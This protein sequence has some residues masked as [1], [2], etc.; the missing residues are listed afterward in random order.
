[1]ADIQEMLC[2]SLG[3]GDFH[4]RDAQRLHQRRRIVVC[5]ISSTE[6]WHRDAHNTLAIVSE[7]VKSAYAHQQ[8]QRRVQTT[9]DAYHHML[10]IGMYQPLGEPCRLDV[11]NL[12]A[13][14]CH[15]VIVG[16]ERMRIDRTRQLEGMLVAHGLAS[17]HL[18][19]SATLGVDE[20]GIGL[21]L[22]MQS[23]D[24]YLGSV[25]N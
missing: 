16:D 13:G 4:L 1:M 24:V 19:V 8:R 14:F 21:P 12:L 15:I 9:T 20:G 5:T 6:S 7:F 2:H 11:E 23:L 17:Y 18:G 22:R 10:A 3:D 25:C